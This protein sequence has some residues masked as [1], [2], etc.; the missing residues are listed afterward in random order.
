MKTKYSLLILFFLP[1]VSYGQVVLDTVN[2]MMEFE[3][4]SLRNLGKELLTQHFIDENKDSLKINFT[5][6]GCFHFEEE[7]LELVKMKNDSLKISFFSKSLHGSKPKFNYEVIKSIDFIEKFI[8]FE[9]AGKN[10]K[11]WGCTTVNFFVLESKGFG[12]IIYDGSCDWE[13]YEELKLAIQL[14]ENRLTKKVK[15]ISRRKYKGKIFPDDYELN[16]ELVDFEVQKRFS[17]SKNEIHS[18]EKIINR[19]KQIRKES[20]NCGRQYL[21]FVNNENQKVIL[22]NFVRYYYESSFNKKFDNL[23]L[24]GCHLSR[25][26]FIFQKMINI[27]TK[28]IQNVKFEIKNCRD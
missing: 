20:S 21:G 5:S 23:Y 11:D 19:N 7:L 18:V 13:G 14:P 6:Q 25:K 15:N 27:E 2:N 24:I 22:V 1:M 4:R 9:K 12:S 3:S 10:I 17:P 16:F 28:E 8:A 26:G